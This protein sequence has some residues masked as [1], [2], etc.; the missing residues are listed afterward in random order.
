MKDLNNEVPVDF[1]EKNG[2]DGKAVEFWCDNHKY[3]QVTKLTLGESGGL[4]YALTDG[5]GEIAIVDDSIVYKDEVGHGVMRIF[6]SNEIP[7]SDG[8]FG[9]INADILI[10]NEDNNTIFKCKNITTIKCGK[11]GYVLHDGRKTELNC[12]VTVG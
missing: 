2:I 8:V 9:G 5:R 11:D 7:V 3:E 10:T 4:T 1:C 6:S 12:S